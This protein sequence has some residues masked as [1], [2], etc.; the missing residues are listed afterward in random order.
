MKQRWGVIV[1]VAVLSFLTGGWLLRGARQQET[2]RGPEL[3]Q[4][5]LQYMSRYYVDSIPNDS[6][7]QLAAAGAV[8]ELGDPYSTLE[9]DQDYQA[10]SEET[11]GNYGGL[12]MQIDIRDG[13]ITVVAPLP[14]TPAERAGILAGDQIEQVNGESTRGISQDKALKVLRGDP[15]T[16]VTVRVHRPG[17][18]DL[19]SF[20]MVRERIH[21]S[22][23]APG[24][25]LSDSVGYVRL[26]TVSDSSAAEL[27][28]Q[29][30]TLLAQGMKGLVLDLRQNPGG[31]LTQGI[32]V[33]GMFLD[34]GRKIVE[35]RGRMADMNHVFSDSAPQLWPKLSVVVLVNE[36]TASAAEIIA[37]ALQ[38]NDRAVVV[39]TATFG[40]GLV[41]T[42]WSFGNGEGFK[43]TT[44][45][46]YTPSGRT[47]QRIAKNQA[48]QYQLAEAEAT[49]SDGH[50]L[51][52]LPSFKTLS[53]RVVKGG[54]G[55]VPDRIVRSDTLTRGETDFLTALGSNVSVY[56]DALVAEAL[57]LKA[58][59][60]VAQPDFVVTDAMRQAV[61]DRMKTKGVSLTPAEVAGGTSL[62]DDQLAYQIDRYVFG[63]GAELRRRTADDPQV[64][65]ALTLLRAGPTRAGLMAQ[66][67]GGPSEQ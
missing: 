38:D 58:A 33:A 53:G 7:Y 8:K 23:V 28:R 44:G 59:H 27:R 5:V 42:L 3:L 57:Q 39:G 30:D 17:I 67:S 50:W 16:H 62:L 10:L 12:G 41:Q 11:T 20:S 46:W 29:V 18:G 63:Q 48:D 14:Q 37:G 19:L 4:T 64:R 2:L 43:L 51:D 32:S 22:S 25:M 31:L 36:Y 49:R 6:L 35:T 65:A 47:I 52:S 61:L 54:G 13:W 56:Q 34:T 55:I 1:V 26:N 66:V 21:S 60:G 45:R 40:K 24:I 15:G 9:Q